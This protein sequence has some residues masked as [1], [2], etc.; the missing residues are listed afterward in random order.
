MLTRANHPSGAACQAERLES[1]TLMSHTGGGDV[2]VEW[3]DIAVDAL[4]VD[5]TYAGPVRAARNMAIVQASV[6][7]A[8]NGVEQTHEPFFVSRPA[9]AGADAEAAAASAGA[10]ALAKLFP[11]QRRFFAAELRASLADV[12]NGPAER[13][14]VRY[15]RYVADRIVA[16]RRYDGSDLEATYEPGNRPGD[17]TP[18]G[19][20]FDE[21]LHVA[22]G[23]MDPFAVGSVDDFL[24]PPPPRLDSAEYAVAYNEVYDLGD[25]VSPFRT[26]DQAQIGDFW[27]YDAPGLGTPVALYNQV[28]QT[29]ALQ[30]GNTV[31]ENARLFAAANV[32]MADAAITAWACKYVDN[33]WRPVTGIHNGDLDG[34][35]DTVADPAWEP[36][37]A[38]GEF[39]DE[40][41]T[42]PFPAYVS[43]HSTLGAAVFRTLENFYGAD[44]VPFELT[45][46]ELPGV[47]RRFASFSHAAAENGDSRIYLGV[48]WRFDDTF[49]QQAGRAVADDVFGEYFAPVA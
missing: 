30:E 18:T 2:V 15:G 25:R 8:V 13:A 34:N 39:V 31:S 5:R 47:V 36:L 6:Y 14:G 41:F 42:P 46:D 27:A 29:L 16:W 23:E 19:P 49:G 26:A 33:L 10:R 44:A 1:R 40:S 12:P 38:P 21:P 28:L 45:S 11:R 43:G 48:H 24:P 32:A 9:P 17:W 20:Q 37:G 3:N 7:D 4:R 35:P 22:A